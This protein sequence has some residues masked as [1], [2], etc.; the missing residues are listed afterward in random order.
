MIDRKKE[1]ERELEAIQKE[2]E[3]SLSEIKNNLDSWTDARYWVHRYPV[4]AVGASLFIGFLLS[5]I[6]GRKKKTSEEPGVSDIFFKELRKSASR[7][8]A[9]LLIKLVEDNL[10]RKR[11]EKDD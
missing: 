1:L 4:H 9:N 2:I 11:R 8:A 6:T 7:S 3:E 10:E 5:Q